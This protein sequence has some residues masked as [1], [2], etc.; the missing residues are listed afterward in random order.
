MEDSSFGAKP[1]YKVADCNI[2]T[3]DILSSPGI[4]QYFEVMQMPTNHGKLFKPNIKKEPVYTLLVVDKKTGEVLKG[5]KLKN[6]LIFAEKT[7][8]AEKSAQQSE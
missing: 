7:I 8:N 3:K 2:A 6:F 4:R 1:K 5:E